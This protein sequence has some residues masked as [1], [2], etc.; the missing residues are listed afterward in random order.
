MSWILL[1]LLGLTNNIQ[2]VTVECADETICSCSNLGPTEPCNFLCTYETA[3]CMYS[4]LYCSEGHPC[5][6]A[7]NGERSCEG[8]IFVANKA[9]DVS[10]ICGTIN[11]N[12]C[13]NAQFDCGTGSCS[14]DCQG[15]CDGTSINIQPETKQFTCSSGCPTTLNNAVFSSLSTNVSTPYLVTN[16]AE[17]TPTKLSQNGASL[18]IDI[19]SLVTDNGL[20]W[21]MNGGTYVDF[22]QHISL[23][24]THWGQQRTLSSQLDITINSIYT[25]GT[26]SDLDLV[27]S[28]SINNT[29]YMSLMIRMDNNDNPRN[30]VHPNCDTSLPTSNTWALGN[31]Q[32][33]VAIDNG[34]G[35]DVK[36]GVDDPAVYTRMQN[37]YNY[38]P[39]QFTFINNPSQDYLEFKYLSQTCYFKSLIPNQGFDVYIGTEQNHETFKISSWTFNYS[40]YATLNPTPY[41][42]KYITYQPTD[43]S[44]NPSISPTLIPTNSP[45]N[46]PT[47]NPSNNP[48]NIPT[49]TPT[50]TAS[51]ISPTISPTIP[52]TITPS[53]I[54]PLISPTIPP[55][56][57]PSKYPTK[58][59][60]NN[61]SQ[62]PTQF[63]TQYPSISPSKYPT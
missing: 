5:S 12:G 6:I 34:Q 53:T 38:W 36:A 13:T 15:S 17:L 42:T 35:R 8:I 26:P 44:S 63:P 16:S 7:C 2:S 11:T 25:S 29:Q 58:Q 51:T 40:Y 37:M 22:H 54:S 31:V 56:E 61:P 47:H 14:M 46:I 57:S 41:P 1:L 50:I 24:N 55:S 10:I 21:T 32:S 20:E 60:T 45:T 30:R 4:T 27:I 28:F 39:L 59:P 23:D 19:P 48:T 49:E 43:S 3:A 18:S 9:T 62:Y 33:L 52:P